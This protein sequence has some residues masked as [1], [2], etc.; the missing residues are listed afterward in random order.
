[1]PGFMQKASAL[2]VTLSNHQI[3]A[4]TVPNKIQAYMAAGRP[5]LACLNGEAEAGL[6][7]PAAVLKIYLMP[8]KEKERLSNNG[9]YYYK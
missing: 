8:V 7:V 4:A 5:I 6:A 9:R 2:L 3:F 1:M